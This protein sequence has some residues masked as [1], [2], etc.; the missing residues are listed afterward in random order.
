M[1]NSRVHALR[2]AEARSSSSGRHYPALGCLLQ[3]VPL[4]GQEE[5][6]WAHHRVRY[7][8]RRR[9]RLSMVLATRRPRRM[10]GWDCLP[11]AAPPPVPPAWRDASTTMSRSRS[12]SHASRLRYWR[13]ATGHSEKTS[14]HV[15]RLGETMIKASIPNAD[16]K[17]CERVEDEVAW[18]AFAAYRRSLRERGNVRTLAAQTIS[19]P[20]T[21]AL[22]GDDSPGAA[23]L[24]SLCLILAS[25]VITP[26]VLSPRRLQCKSHHRLARQRDVVVPR[27]L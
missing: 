21:D 12:V 6:H 25:I 24:A 4:P 13:S 23:S 26:R 16:V 20:V 27:H 2:G 9:A 8:A 19:A 5:A 22:L 1:P 18:R 15:K 14:Y 10:C 17:R 7:C 11:H 3:I